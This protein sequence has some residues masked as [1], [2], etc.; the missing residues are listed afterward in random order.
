MDKNKKTTEDDLEEKD[1]IIGAEEA[2]DE[3]EDD[4]LEE[5][6]SYEEEAEEEEEEDGEEEKDEE[7]NE[8]DKEED[9]K[10]DDGEIEMEEEELN[11]LTQNNEEVIETGDQKEDLTELLKEIA[12]NEN[13]KKAVKRRKEWEYGSL[14]IPQK[15]RK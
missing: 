2:D 11:T 1:V 12:A 10:S 14:S 3:I 9:I 15:K 4:D 5:D 7:D 13:L 6:D 8:E